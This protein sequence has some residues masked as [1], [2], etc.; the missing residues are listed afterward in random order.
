M[1]SNT[2]APSLRLPANCW[3]RPLRLTLLLTAVLALTSCAHGT[4]ATAEIPPP[5]LALVS[6]VPPLP[7][8]LTAPCP[9]TLPPA[10]DSRIGGLGRNHLQSAAIYH[11][12]RAAQAS[13]AAA[14]RER[15]RIELQRIERARQALEQ[16]AE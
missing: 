1:S 8:E 2:T 13:L 15:E 7:P 14:A 9:Q 4:R 5:L 12:C 11:D 16:L 3:S 10:V 6:P